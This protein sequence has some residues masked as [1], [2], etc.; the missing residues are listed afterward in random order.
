[1]KKLIIILLLLPIWTYTQDTTSV[2]VCT[3]DQSHLQTYSVTNGPNQYTWSVTGGV[4]ENGNG[5]NTIVV[6]WFNVPYSM[7]LIE[8]SVI[9]DVGCPGNTSQ[10]YVDI[11]ECS[12]DGVY[13]PN[14]FTPDGDEVNEM[15]GP[16]FSPGYELTEFTLMVFNRWGNILWESHNQYGKWDGTYDGKLCQDG[17]YVWKM[18]YKSLDVV[19]PQHK[20]GHVTLLR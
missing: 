10:L 7:Y 11:D 15:W 13:V 2:K 6:N 20:H 4:I 5:T 8:V 19:G 14:C 9:S 18:R 16:V 12:Y 3:H 17:V 1:M